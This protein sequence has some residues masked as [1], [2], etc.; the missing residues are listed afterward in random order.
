MSAAIANAGFEGVEIFQSPSRIYVFDREQQSRH[1]ASIEEVASCLKQHGLNF[2]GLQ[3]G[4]LSERI[5]FCQSASES[6]AAALGITLDDCRPT[7]LYIEDRNDPAVDKALDAGFNLALHPHVFSKC[8]RIST[9]MR[10][11]NMDHPHLYW[12]TDTAHIYVAGEDPIEEIAKLPINKLIV[13]HLKDWD[14]AY[15]RSYHRYAK[16][17]V[18]LGEGVVPLTAVLAKLREICFDGWLIVEQDYPNR[19]IDECLLLSQ[20]WLVSQGLILPKPKPFLR[21]T[22][23]T[24]EKSEVL[25][26]DSAIT[27][28]EFVANLSQALNK[29]LVTC[30]QKIAEALYRLFSACHVAI[31]SYSPARY[32]TCLLG[33]YP[34]DM[35]WLNEPVEID[36]REGLVGMGV[37]GTVE[38]SLDQAQRPHFDR[39]FQWTGVVETHQGRSVVLIPIPNGYNPHHIRLFISLMQKTPSL[40]NYADI[41]EKIVWEIARAADNA[42]DEICAYA[43]AKVNFLA[44]QA[45]SSARFLEG[46]IPLIQRLVD[47]QGVTIFLESRTGDLLIARASSGIEW[48]PS[49][50]EAE[51]YYYPYEHEHPTCRCWQDATNIILSEFMERGLEGT[52]ETPK[53]REIDD[54]LNT[55]QDN[56]LLVPLISKRFDREG[57]Q[58]LSA[59]GVVRCRN[60]KKQ[61]LHKYIA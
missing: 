14:A 46:L 54:N 9:A 32:E 5:A 13:V 45:L 21:S 24:T 31:W 7:Y 18:S 48:H 30:Y 29:N 8:E 51:R 3:G 38:I 17:F 27:Y 28:A 61:T 41:A 44:Q 19:S 11:F 58:H 57:K 15:G 34:F 4:S 10:E 56:V 20:Q 52:P 40:Y 33:A 6:R 59:L 23:A 50:L 37:E 55:S 22:Q 47:C 35:Y 60:K 26:A 25:C 39:T 1:P 16:G 12:M 2:L 49:L 36:R 42:L 53:S 43:V